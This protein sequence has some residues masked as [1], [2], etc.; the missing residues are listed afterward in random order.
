MTKKS[1]QLLALAG[2]TCFASTA[3]AQNPPTVTKSFSPTTIAIG[4]TSQIPLVIANPNASALLSGVN[5]TD[6]L[7]AGLVFTPTFTQPG[8]CG[9][10][11]TI[12]ATTITLSNLQIQPGDK[13]TVDWTVRGIAAGVWTNTTSA[14]TSIQG[15]S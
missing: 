5:L 14:P 12:T 3:F 11:L 8:F 9:G 1:L 7:P 6:T 13:C 10:S 2:L 4:S 15:G